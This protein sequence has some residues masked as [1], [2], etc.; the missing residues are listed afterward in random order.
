MRELNQALITEIEYEGECPG[1][2]RPSLEA[3]FTSSQTP[4][5]PGRRVIVRNVTRGL[6]SDPYPY[7]NR[8][9]DQGRSSESTR[10]LFGTRHDGKQFTV[11]EGENN[12]EYEIRQGDRIIDSGK[13]TAVIDKQVD[14]RRRDA[15]ASTESICMN[16][17]V[18]LNLCADIRTRTQH[19]C[20]NGQVVRSLLEPDYREISTL[21]SNQT[22]QPMLFML[23]G[24]VERLRPGDSRTTTGNSL[25]IR[26]HPTCRNC[27]PNQTLNLQPGKRYQFRGSQFNSNV[28][29]LVDFPN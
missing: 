28:V 7:T 2:E 14:A 19:K 21:I 15:I 18:S 11:L 1:Q 25:S 8:E 16:S 20:P 29:E 27:Q 17:A 12:F 3:K 26:F 13:F 23:N 9:Y 4:P 5:A 10:M 24:R 6:A 22:F